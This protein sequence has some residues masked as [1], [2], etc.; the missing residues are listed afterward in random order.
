MRR[1]SVKLW[2]RHLEDAGVD[3]RLIRSYLAY[4]RRMARA[5]LPPIFEIRHLSQLLGRTLGY[6]ASVVNCPEAHYR[7]FRLR[8][9]RG[10]SRSI[11]APYPALLECQQWIAE[12]ILSRAPLH[13][14]AHGFRKGKSILMNAEPHLGARCL[15]KLDIR[16]FFP[17]IGISRVIAVFRRLGYPPNV[18]F[19]LARLCCHGDALPQGAATSPALSNIIAAKMDARLSGLS[20]CFGLVYTRYADDMTFSGARMSIKTVDS[21]S[22]IVTAEGFELNATKTRLCRKPGRRIVTGI[23]VSGKEPALP[24]A[25]KRQLRQDAHYVMRYGNSSHVGK[26]GIR[27]PFYL[28]SLYGKLLFWQWV[29]PRNSF[30]NSCLPVI[31]RIRRER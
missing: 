30:V 20:T 26:R 17:S 14:A 2:R 6:V 27:D 19:Y 21:I 12:N 31:Q 29:E 5:G 11:C 28:D 7:T 24:R 18:S 10:G 1:A 15:L 16:D 13:G 3:S 4:V 9:R 23:S 25:L 22:A 8:K